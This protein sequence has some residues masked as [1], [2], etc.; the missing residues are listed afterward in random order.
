MYLSDAELKMIND[1]VLPD[2]LARYRDLFLIAAYTGLRYSDLSNLDN[3]HIRPPYVKIRTQKTGERVVIP[4]HPVLK[5]V[6]ERNN[7]EI[8]PVPSN[9][10]FNE[11]IKDVCEIAEIKEICFLG[12]TIG[13]KYVQDK[14]PKYKLVS[15]HT[16]RRSFATNMYLAGVP[17]ISIMKITGHHSEKSF[18]K[19]IRISQEDNAQKLLDHP[20]FK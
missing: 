5:Q 17:S 10:K 18:L 3:F 12:K 13:G 11:Y 20:Y 2:S 1:A 8:P 14:Y 15:A 9:Q 19:Y 4:I 16:A 7:Y 6:L